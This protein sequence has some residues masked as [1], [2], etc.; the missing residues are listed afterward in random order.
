MASQHRL[1]IRPFTPPSHTH[2]QTHTALEYPNVYLL[3]VEL[4]WTVRW[5]SKRADV[6]P[7]APTPHPP[8]V[9]EHQWHWWNGSLHTCSYSDIRPW[10]LSSCPNRIWGNVLREHWDVIYTVVC[11]TSMICVHVETNSKAA[12]LCLQESQ[13]ILDHGSQIDFRWIQNI[14][15]YGT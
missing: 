3:G 13:F 14:N 10:S 2:T 9:C 1:Q 4:D 15:L 5:L 12:I 6:S 7:L 11:S 8:N